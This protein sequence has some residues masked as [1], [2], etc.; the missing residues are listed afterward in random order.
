M[1]K[2][3]DRHPFNDRYVTSGWHALQFDIIPGWHE[4]L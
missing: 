4:E 1:A 3:I 2:E